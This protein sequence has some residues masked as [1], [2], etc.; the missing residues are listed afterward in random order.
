MK[1]N[2]KIPTSK[3]ARATK[4]LK[5][6]AKVGGNYV[7]FYSKKI[8]NPDI[9]RDELDKEN[10][11]DIFDSLSELKGGALKVIQ[12]ISMD[13]G[14]LPTE[15]VK[16]FAEAQY[17][18]PALSYPLVVKTFRQY[19]GKG[20]DEIFDTFSKQAVHAASIGQVHEATLNGKKLAVKVQY[21]GVADSMQSDLRMVKPLATTLFRIKQAD[22]EHYMEEVE[23]RLMEE[24][25]YVNELK[26]SMEI[27]SA[28]K[29]LA[30][31]V[32][33]NY[34]PEWS[35]KR[36]LTMDWIE[37][38][39]IDQYLQ[40]IHGQDER[41]SIGQALWDFYDFQVHKLKMVHADPH[42]GNFLVTPDAKL[43]ILD[44][45]CVKRLPEPFYGNF[46][47]MLHADVLKNDAE[48]EKLFLNLQ[49]L[50][51]NDTPT[52]R[53]FFF[54]LSKQVVEMLT[55]PF[56][57]ET[58]DFSGDDYFKEVSTFGERM[59]KSKEIRETKVV[60]GPRDGIYL[61]RVYYGLYHLLHE[62][63]ATIHTRS[64]LNDVA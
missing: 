31:L 52:E 7:K 64:V 34:Y 58:F 8:V 22:V 28:C 19:F 24:T 27:S 60:R 36:I 3:V 42:P 62:L 55:R 63:G 46:R 29:G 16:K 5:T 2:D 35:N 38:T 18:A 44:F 48:L 11:E 6:G 61:G 49:F 17:K 21:P 43:A 40:N 9:S 30:N 33:P 53:K 47:Q 45:G 23:S 20:P 14:T 4:F 15:Y 51:P 26:Q 54:D 32:F 41:N 10:A 57:A 1:E 13:R 59:S 39:H 56:H 12:M 37:G 50:N 25:D